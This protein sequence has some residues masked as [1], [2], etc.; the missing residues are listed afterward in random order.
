MDEW[1]MILAE[2]YHADALRTTYAREAEYSL[3]RSDYAMPQERF[4]RTPLVLHFGDHLQLPPVPASG[5]LLAPLQ[6]RSNEHKAGSAIFCNSR[7]VYQFHTAM[8][9]TDTVL[10]DIL[11]KMRQPSGFV[12]TAEEKQ[13][14]L[15]TELGTKLPNH[16][17]V[18]LH[19]CEGYYHGCYVWSVTSM[20]C[21]VEAKASAKA[22]KATLFYAQA[23]D[24]LFCNVPTS[25]LPQLYRDILAIPSLP[26]TQRLPGIAMFH[27]GMRVRLY[28]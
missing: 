3:I 6:G 18:S 5:S 25:S 4:G 24:L 11:G 19:G 23:V 22:A 17:T 9:F 15:E 2:L 20:A 10:R 26:N 12:L 8:R 13:K 28:Q 14:L 7:H 27:F 21:F 1:M 16:E